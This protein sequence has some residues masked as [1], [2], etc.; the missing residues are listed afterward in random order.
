MRGTVHS[1][2]RLPAARAFIA[3]AALLAGAMVSAAH[4]QDFGSGNG[5][6]SAM[7]LPRNATRGSGGVVLPHPL[8]PSEANRVGRVFALQENGSLDKAI[9]EAEALTD[10]LLLGSILAQRYLGRFH[11][12][13]VAE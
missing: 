1:L 8:A 2:S 3:G 11:R 10:P 7:A 13:T 4:A 9:R 12:A 5:D 6:E